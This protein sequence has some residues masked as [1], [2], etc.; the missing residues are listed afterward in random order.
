MHIISRWQKLASLPLSENVM[1]LLKNELLLPFEQD[2]SVISTFWEEP[3]VT[4]IYIEPNDTPEMI[5]D[6]WLSAVLWAID[7][8][9]FVI[10]LTSDYYLMLSVTDDSG[11][12]IYL[13]FQPECPLKGITQLVNIAESS[14]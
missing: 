9:E 10:R 5:A 7:N 3:G 8:P 6:T 11:A 14:I 12:G 13:L 2:E 4:L 1:M